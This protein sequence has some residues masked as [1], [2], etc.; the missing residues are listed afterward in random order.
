[1]DLAECLV[2]KNR[3]LAEK[4]VAF[5]LGSDAADKVFRRLVT[6]DCLAAGE[7]RMSD[8]IMRGALFAALYR[9]D[10]AKEQPALL[11]SP[12][13]IDTTTVASANRDMHR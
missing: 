9:V 3:A 8:R 1:M 13:P 11:E 5:P 10:F 6:A 4:S 7:A 12:I 2:L